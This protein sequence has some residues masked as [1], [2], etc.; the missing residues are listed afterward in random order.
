MPAP[1][2]V[3]RPPAGGLFLSGVAVARKGCRNPLPEEDGG[4]CSEVGRLAERLA[5]RFLLGGELEAARLGA[6]RL[7]A[8]DRDG[9]VGVQHPFARAG[10]GR[11]ARVD[12]VE[13]VDGQRHRHPDAVRITNPD[14]IFAPFEGLNVPPPSM[15]IPPLRRAADEDFERSLRVRHGLRT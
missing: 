8:A 2:A 5:V 4:D 1:P 6:A 3:V 15:Q 13:T 11:L 14:G 9:L 12:G 10:R 7:P